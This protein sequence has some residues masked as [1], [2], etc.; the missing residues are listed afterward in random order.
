MKV[1]SQVLLLICY[2]LINLPAGAQKPQTGCVDAAIQAQA[3]GIK[4]G[5]SKKGMVVFQEAMFRMQSMEPVPVAVKMT[6]GVTYELVFVGSEN[7][8]KLMM[9]LYDGKDKK[10]DEKIERSMNN[11]IYTFTPQR[12]DV[13]LV[14][15]IQKKGL[16]DM[17]GYFGVMV[18]GK[19]RKATPKVDSTKKQN[20]PAIQPAVKA[21]PQQSQPTKVNT[22]KSNNAQSIPA[23]QRPNPNRTKATRE[24]QEQKGK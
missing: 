8:N 21:A 1:R 16:K 18:K 2:L 13:Y 19:P 23:N 12:T 3:D 6:Q 22:S 7:T 5:L 24:A 9:E 11:I 20:I 14:T 15:L 10:I 4:L 17:C